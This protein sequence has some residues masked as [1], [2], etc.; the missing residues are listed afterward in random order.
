MHP[1]RKTS[2]SAHGIN[3]WQVPDLT[4]SLVGGQHY[5]AQFP[6]LRNEKPEGSIFGARWAQGPI[7]SPRCGVAFFALFAGVPYRVSKYHY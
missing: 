5:A 3:H 7:E 2:W 1:G 4:E 6:N